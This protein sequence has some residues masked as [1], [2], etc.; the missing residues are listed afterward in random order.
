M[1]DLFTINNLHFVTWVAMRWADI[2]VQ[3]GDCWYKQHPQL[4]KVSAV[5]KSW[6]ISTQHIPIYIF[7]PHCVVSPLLSLCWPSCG[8]FGLLIPIVM[9]SSGTLEA[10]SAVPRLFGEGLHHF[11]WNNKAWWQS[12]V[13]TVLLLKAPKAECIQNPHAEMKRTVTCRVKPSLLVR[14]WGGM[15]SKKSLW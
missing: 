10:L 1:L 9:T 8:A 12:V 14:W 3:S 15:E 13:P 5:T 4:S 6:S 2:F 7:P 11:M